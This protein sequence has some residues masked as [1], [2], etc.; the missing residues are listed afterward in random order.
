MRHLVPAALLAILVFAGPSYAVEPPAPAAATSATRQAPSPADMQ[1]MMSAAMDG[2]VPL[3]GRMTEV[4]IDAQLNSA[5][6]PQTAER[7]ATFKKN[8]YDALIKKG[9]AK[10]EALQI[11]IATGI[12][13]ATPTS[14]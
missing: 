8:L 5:A 9:F 6:Q 14:K 3:M 2:M 4:M 13:S 1:K 11:V 12:P 10:P 7:I